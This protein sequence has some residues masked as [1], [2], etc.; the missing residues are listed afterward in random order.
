LRT[1]R[2]VRILRLIR[3]MSGIESIKSMVRSMQ[4]LVHGLSCVASSII[5]AFFVM[6]M[7]IYICDIFI[8]EAVRS[9]LTSNLLWD[10][11]EVEILHRFYKDIGETS[12]T[13]LASVTGGI[14]WVESA[15]PLEKISGWY[16]VLYQA[17]VIFAMLCI[18]NIIAGLFVNVSMSAGTL[19]NDMEIDAMIKEETRYVQKLV[20][21][22]ADSDTDHSNTVSWDELT[23]HLEDERVKAYFNT[24]KLDMKTLSRIFELLDPDGDGEID[25]EIFAKGCIEHRGLAA[26]VDVVLLRNAID[27]VGK[28][29]DQVLTDAK[30]AS[31]AFFKG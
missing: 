8:L 11:G 10:E 27:D 19:E 9:Y 22:L 7:C 12:F 18:L 17:Y 16:K 24:L 31:R 13:L 5:P 2:L 20:E 23:T 4:T 1:A 28:K 15:T 21:L 6:G 14:N 26:S 3:A 30:N 29:V 25:I